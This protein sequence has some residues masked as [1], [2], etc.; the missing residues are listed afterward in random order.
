MKRFTLTVLI[1]IGCTFSLSSSAAT[2]L[3]SP[4]QGG[5]KALAIGKPRALKITVEGQGPAGTL[6]GDSGEYYGKL[7][8]DLNHLETGIGLRDR[9]LK[10]KYIEVEKHPRSTLTLNRVK[11]SDEELKTGVENRSFEG[12]LHFHGVERAVHGSFDLKPDGE[13]LNVTARFQ[14]LLTDYQ[15]EIPSYLGIQVAETVEIEIVSRLK[16]KE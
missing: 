12:S 6:V 2:F 4:D 3:L 11:L 9:H 5:L 15:V 16:K 7:T 13:S 1:A 14:I 8:L 10:E